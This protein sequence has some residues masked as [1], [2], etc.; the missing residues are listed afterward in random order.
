MHRGTI[1]AKL[2]TLTKF[3][4]F[5]DAVELFQ[6]TPLSVVLTERVLTVIFNHERQSRGGNNG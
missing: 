3:G 6:D 2:P 1:W 5:C 4:A